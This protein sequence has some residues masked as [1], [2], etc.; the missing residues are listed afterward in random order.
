MGI[1]LVGSDLHSIVFSRS[2]K[3]SELIYRWTRD[4]LDEERRTRIAPYRGGYLAAERRKIE[5]R[6]F[7]GDLLGVAATNALELGVDVG[8]LDAAVITTFP[9][10]ISSFRQQAGRSGRRQRT[11]LAVLVAGQDAL[12]QYYMGHPQQLFRRL[13]SVRY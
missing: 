2:R 8:G 4:R 9:G 13:I 12:D 3:S 5:A 10:T 7:S 1:D 11:S 6:L